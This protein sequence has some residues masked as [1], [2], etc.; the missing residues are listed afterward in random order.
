MLRA[1]V[2]DGRCLSWRRRGKSACSVGGRHR[3]KAA[4]PFL[5]VARASR[6]TYGHCARCGFWNIGLAVTP[7]G[8]VD[9]ASHAGGRDCGPRACGRLRREC[10]SGAV[11]RRTCPSRVADRLQRCIMHV[12]S[13]LPVRFTSERIPWQESGQ[14]GVA[15]RAD[16]ALRSLAEP[17]LIRLS[18][19]TAGD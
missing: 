16:H 14:T 12:R 5:P 7:R 15:C 8:L 19:I 17:D 1:G 3:A 11:D 18:L 4:R 10:R 6:A 13:F 9:G 2:W